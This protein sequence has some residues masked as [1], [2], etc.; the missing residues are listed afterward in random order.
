MGITPRN[1]RGVDFEHVRRVCQDHTLVGL[2]AILAASDK[3]VRFLYMSGAGAERDQNKKPWVEARYMLMRVGK[4]VPINFSICFYVEYTL[5]S[6]HAPAM[7]SFLCPNP[8]LPEQKTT[9]E[10]QRI[11]QTAASRVPNLHTYPLFAIVITSP[12]QGETENQL[13]TFA[14]EHSPQLSLCIVKPGFITASGQYLRTAFSTVLHYTIS[15]PKI[16]VRECAAAM[17]SEVVYGFEKETLE[18]GELVVKG[19]KVLSGGGK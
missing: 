8:S 5:L 18:N 7:R 17:L 13:L 12:P 9:F 4:Q 16:D 19:K 14:S 2:K 11:S 6:R 1:T 15:L 3:N 10:I